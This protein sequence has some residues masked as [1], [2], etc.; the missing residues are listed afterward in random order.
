MLT[1]LIKVL[2]SICKI[3]KGPVSAQVTEKKFEKM[4]SQGLN[5]AK[6]HKNIIIKVPCNHEGLKAAKILK[7]KKLKLM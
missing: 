7:K 3:V 5:L 1:I 6:I 2:K 4:V